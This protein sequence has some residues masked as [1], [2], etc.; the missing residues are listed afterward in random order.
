MA[1]VIWLT[2]NVERGGNGRS[3]CPIESAYSQCRAIYPRFVFVGEDARRRQLINVTV[4]GWDVVKFGRRVCLHYPGALCRA[5]QR[6]RIVSV[7]ARVGQKC[8][9]NIFVG[10]KVSCTALTLFVRCRPIA[11]GERE[12]E[13]GRKSKKI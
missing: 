12:W 2:R 13:R 6:R 3:R 1:V 9:A 4:L 10:V 5:G 11:K 7:A 8:P